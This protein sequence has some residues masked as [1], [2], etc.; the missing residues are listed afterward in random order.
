MSWLKKSVKKLGKSTKK[1]V[2]KAVKN[3]L[4]IVNPTTYFANAGAT[5]PLAA[6]AGQSGSD[7][8]D[9]AGSI[10]SGATLA[11]GAV[12]GGATIAGPALSTVAK[13]AGA[14]LGGGEGGLDIIGGLKELFSSRL[15]ELA[16][17]SPSYS[18]PAPVAAPV[19]AEEGDANQAALYVGLGLAALVLVI[20]AGKAVR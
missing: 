11:G 20:V 19:V 14:S 9:D 18:E 10:A 1:L 12:L 13:D 17:P 15:A 6:A 3:P 2:K 5:A 4:A 16:A 8:A 7:F